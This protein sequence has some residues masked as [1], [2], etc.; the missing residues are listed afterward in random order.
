MYFD[1]HDGHKE[2]KSLEGIDNKPKEFGAT[3]YCLE[4]HKGTIDQH[5]GVEDDGR[6]AKGLKGSGNDLEGL[7]D[8]GSEHRKLDGADSDAGDPKGVGETLRFTNNHQGLEGGGSKLGYLDGAD[9]FD[10]DL[11][12]GDNDLEGHKEGGDDLADLAGAGGGDDELEETG[13]TG[14]LLLFLPQPRQDL[15]ILCNEDSLRHRQG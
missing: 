3:D 9:S 8:G 13:D 6:D 15:N 10:G 12:G 4:G 7:E 11:K 5:M 1:Q 14:E 2:D